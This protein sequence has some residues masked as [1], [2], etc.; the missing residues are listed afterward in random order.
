MTDDRGYLSDIRECIDRIEAY[1]RDGRAAFMA[2]TLIQDGVVRN[3]EVIGEAV[4]RL[5][6]A[7]TQSQP[8]IPWRRVA[9]FRDVLIHQ[10]RGIDLH[11]VWNVVER[12]LPGLK[13]AVA[14][15]LVQLD[16]QP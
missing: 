6:P 12:E 2:S 9:G 16:A 8:E 3:F 15:L 4:K 13:R 7:L 10:Y 14:A 5:T 11:A 1:T